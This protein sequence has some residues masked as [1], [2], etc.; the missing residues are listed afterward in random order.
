MS[1]PIDASA[2]AT[3]SRPCPPSNSRSLLDLLQGGRI[4][5]S[6]VQFATTGALVT[7]AFVREFHQLEAF[8]AR[9]RRL[10]VD[11]CT[12]AYRWPV[13]PLHHW[14]RL[15]EYPFVSLALK[16]LLPAGG[17][18]V[19]IGS[20]TT[21]FP[22]Y[23]TDRCSI[24]VVAVDPDPFHLEHFSGAIRA[25]LRNTPVSRLP[26][27]KLA[28]G[29]ETG[30]PTSSVDVAYS[31]SVIEHIPDFLLVVREM[32][33]IVKPGGYLLLTVDVSTSNSEG[34]LTDAQLARLLSEL[35]IMSC[36]PNRPEDLLTTETP[37]RFIPN[38]R[39]PW[40]VKINPLSRLPRVLLTRLWNRNG[41][42]VGEVVPE[43]SLAVL[44]IVW[45]KPV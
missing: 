17:R 26:I 31:I 13:D 43:K 41:G 2:L 11:W 9:F 40:M 7:D 36:A 32:K 25:V 10:L 27:P 42:H 1:E 24:D 6:L 18:A 14:S 39:K 30:L 34:G 16:K 29:D 37:R 15:W 8:D 23:L 21:F 38:D 19:D 35:G 20:A 33:R 5:T 3:S 28:R 12:S 44:G 4:E 45:R 22:F